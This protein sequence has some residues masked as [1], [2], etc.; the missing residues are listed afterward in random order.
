MASLV[1]WHSEFC[2]CIKTK[3]VKY[4]TVC[5]N[6]ILFWLADSQLYRKAGVADLHHFNADPN[7]DPSFHFNADPDLHSNTRYNRKRYFHIIAC[8]R[9]RK[10]ACS[11][12]I[13]KL[14][15]AFCVLVSCKDKMCEISYGMYQPRSTYTLAN[16]QLYREAGVA[17]SHPSFH[18]VGP[19]PNFQF[20]V[21]PDPTRN[22]SSANV[23]LLC[24]NLQTKFWACFCENW[25][26]K[27][28]H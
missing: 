9:F 7:T 27:F 17:H 22:Q 23:R 14:P 19:G 10:L 1:N 15:V 13:G 18:Y 11:W 5:I 25:V 26:C 3:C 20:N 6:H 2:F 24:P 16:I 12:Q 28:G 21:D 8:G 4:R